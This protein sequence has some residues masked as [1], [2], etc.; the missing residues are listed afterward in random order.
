MSAANAE[1]PTW[2]T[3]TATTTSTTAAT[4]RDAA[5]NRTQIRSADVRSVIGRSS[6]ADAGSPAG[7]R[8]LVRGRPGA[9]PPLDR[10]CS[11]IAHATHSGHVARLRRVVAQLLPQP[12]DVLVD[13][14]VGHV[15]LAL[16]MDRVEQLVAAEDPPVR[17]EQ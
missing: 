10:P 3:P 17:R 15:T 9:R 11:A 2:R 7:H 8:A 16:A 4:S 1:A 14:P 5:R 6:P 13:G 12:L